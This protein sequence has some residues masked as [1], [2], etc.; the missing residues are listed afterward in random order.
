MKTQPRTRTWALLTL[1]ALGVAACQDDPVL[2]PVQERGDPGVEE[3]PTPP[4]MNPM[5]QGVEGYPTTG[6]IRDGWILDV[7]G[8]PRAITYEIHDGLAIWQGDIVLGTPDEIART[9]AEIG[10]SNQGPLR[11]VVIN[12][13][14]G[15]NRWPGGVIPYTI[16]ASAPPTQSIVDGAIDLIEDQTPGVTLVPRSGESD[17]V[18]F[19]DA[20]G[21]SSSI[22]R[23]GGQQFINLKV[24]DGVSFCSTGNAAHEI[25][26][27]LGMYHEHTRCDRDGFVTIDY[28]EIEAGKEG[29]FFKA[30]SGSENGACSGAFDIGAYDFGSMMHYPLDAFAIG[31]NNTIIPI[32]PIPPGT[33]IG[34]RS[35]VGPTD[36]ATID[37]LYG[38]NNAAPSVVVD[39]LAAS[40]PEGTPVPFDASGTSDP[41]DDDDLITFSWVFGDGT[42]P[43]PAACSDDNPAHA[44]ADNG[45]YGWSVSASDGFDASA[46]GTTIDI[47]NV[48]PTVNAGAPT[49]SVDEGMLW[50]RNG[51]F[52]DPG[53][54][55][56]SATVDYDDGAGAQALALAGK[57]FSLSNT[58]VDNGVNTV[59]V[60]VADDDGGVGQDEVEV[61]VDNVAPTVDAGADA[62]VESGETFDF[63]GTF[64]DPGIEDDPWGWV[65]DW[66]FGPNTAG[67]TDDQA[68]PIE[69]SRQVC[70]AGTY[71][72]SLTVTD[73]DGGVGSDD[74]ELTVP[75]IEVEIDI[76]P[77]TNV[78][79]VNLRSGG[80]VPVAVLGS[81]ELDVTA[82]DASTLI[83]G[84][85]TDPETSVAQKNNGAYEAHLEDVNDDGYMDLVALFPM[86]D[87]VENGDLDELSTELVLRAFQDDGCT[88]LRG[89]DA[90]L[91]QGT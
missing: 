84:N 37:Q 23:I 82:I 50:G 81:A 68:A 91:P 18:T 33:V 48:A 70:V 77:G 43:G 85:E 21:C 56:W 86:R 49:S 46:F 55:T 63:V 13:D 17:Y 66:G 32:A 69:A 45:T 3:T 10:P 34:Q 88:H 27:A 80:R 7:D 54:D 76:L 64:S 58:W 28:D 90:V 2:L 83:L 40:Y 39:A 41:D 36:V 71:T 78:N 29:N 47:T 12:A 67:S 22:G 35:A 57:T 20:S 79:P 72:V 9:P 61:T 42:C 8:T 16:S 51:S 14:G 11:G 53:A 65:I 19:Q 60:E 15:N 6:E 74:M 1:A 38:A 25:L 52:T 75:Y 44:Y 4:T 62:E 73:K 59:V 89:V 87:L 26:H 24:D 30:G 31:S 5:S